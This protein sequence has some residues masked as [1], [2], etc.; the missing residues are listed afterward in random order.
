MR[1]IIVRIFHMPLSP[2]AA[3]RIAGV[4]RSM[5]SKEVKAGRLPATINN[6]TGHISILE[7]DLQAW[8]DRRVKRDSIPEPK[9]K[10]VAPPPAATPPTA[11]EVEAL[12]ADLA[13]TRAMVARLEG[14][15][16]VTAARLADLSA[17]RDAWRAQAERLSEARAVPV[18]VSL[19]TRLFG[20]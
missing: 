13:E 5:I 1:N 17:D 15:A 3:G 6:A 11:P 19:W 7:A 8:I 20:R 16:E 4:S 10:P 14:Q 9:E 18:P 2:A 12:R